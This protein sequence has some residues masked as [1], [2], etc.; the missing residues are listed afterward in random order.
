MSAYVV[1]IRE[2]TRDPEQMSI[3][4]RQA[5]L[6]REGHPI[7]PIVKYGALHILEGASIEGCLIHHFP[8]VEDAERWY[9]S[10]KYQEAARHR[11]QGADYRVFIVNG[12][13]E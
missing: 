5:P 13:E 12:V 9:H 6:A 4:A 8:T 2:K 1:M 7:T 10:P 3:Y 11:H